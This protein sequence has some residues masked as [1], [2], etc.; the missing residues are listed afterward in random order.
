MTNDPAETV[1][2]NRKTATAARQPKSEPLRGRK[3]SWRLVAAAL[4][5]LI[6]AGVSYYLIYPQVAASLH[7]RRAQRALAE[8]DLAR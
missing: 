3:G 1:A 6:L 7:W 4:S 8:H 5:L 2:K